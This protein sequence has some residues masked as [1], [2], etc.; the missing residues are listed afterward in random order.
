MS[1]RI[2]RR[3]LI[4][5]SLLSVFLIAQVAWWI[6][7]QVKI[8]DHISTV[9]RQSWDQQIVA[10]R[11]WISVR[12]HADI[13]LLRE[14]LAETF[15][16]L[17]YVEKTGA[18]SIRETAIEDL[19]DSTSRII[20]MLLFEG[21]FFSLV[22]MVGLLYMYRT[23]RREAQV[24]RHFSSFLT[25]TTHELKTPLTA[26]N[27]FV[28]ALKIPDRTGEQ[29]DE[30]Y[31]SLKKNM[32]RLDLLITKLLHARGKIAVT[33]FRAETVD[34]SQATQ[35]IVDEFS[36]MLHRDDA[37]RISVDISSSLYAR[38]DL[39]QWRIL[40]SNL[41]ENAL[42]YSKKSDPVQVAL[43]GIKKSIE[44]TVIDQGEGFDNAE[45]KMIFK[46]FYRIGDV[47]NSKTK[48][49]G[50]GLF[51]VEE[52]AANLGGK[53]SAHSDGPGKGAIF[54]VTIPRVD[55]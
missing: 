15:P 44:L 5:F 38:T 16:D 34:L 27:L 48:G 11:Q 12:G 26:M 36:K 40:V 30:I 47:D 13:H 25:A 20:R 18:V 51:L 37:E 42:K 4:L 46:R 10:A 52:I 49:T 29:T 2:S 19:E 1:F 32:N 31:S 50:I 24:E 35:K 8:G 6:I 53:V 28:D 21:A 7:L 3:R 33:K 23:L 45:R 54:R 55:V 39:D 43:S 41:I 14:W 17:E 9:Q 22:V